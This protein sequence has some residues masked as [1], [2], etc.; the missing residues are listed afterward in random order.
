MKGKYN[1]SSIVPYL[2]ALIE[3][4]EFFGMREHLEIMGIYAYFFDLSDEN[5]GH[6]KKIFNHVRK[7]D[8]EFS[9]KWFNL[10]LELHEHE[11]DLDSNADAH[12]SAIL[13]S[14]IKDDLTEK[15]GKQA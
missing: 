1:N 14:K 4:E 9:E 8:P 3:E 7:K 10:N 5:L 2:K 15:Q 11:I 13:D 6:L 12:I